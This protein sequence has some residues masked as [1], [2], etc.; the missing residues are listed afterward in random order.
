VKINA[1]GLKDKPWADEKISKATQ[2]F[3]NTEEKV[4]SI[5]QEVESKI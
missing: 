4:K 1:S 5:M 2:I 3:E